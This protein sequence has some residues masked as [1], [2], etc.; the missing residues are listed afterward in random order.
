M[1]DIRIDQAASALA[2]EI[3]RIHVAARDAYYSRYA[4]A[5]GSPGAP[6]QERDYESMWRTRLNSGDHTVLVAAQEDLLLGFVAM[7]RTSL[8]PHD[9]DDAFE[10]SGLYVEPSAWGRVI[11]GGLYDAFEAEWVAGGTVTA[12]LD[13]WSENARAIRFYHSRGWRPDGQVRPGP[14]GTTYNRMLLS[15][16]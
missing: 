8:N 11:G 5:P 2:G 3:A 1:P 4:P 16:P 13:V 10:L 9:R 6:G 12:V 7:T 14:G 15:G